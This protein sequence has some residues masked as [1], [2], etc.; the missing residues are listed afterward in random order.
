MTEIAI[1][2]PDIAFKTVLCLS[3]K[4]LTEV[5]P[6]YSD[7]SVGASIIKPAIKF[8]NIVMPDPG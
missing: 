8:R 4:P 7:Q 6:L 2:A 5:S 1:E 3:I